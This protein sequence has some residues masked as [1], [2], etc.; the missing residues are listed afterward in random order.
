MAQNTIFPVLSWQNGD[1]ATKL[2]TDKNGVYLVNNADELRL[3]S[4][5][6]RK[7]T[8]FKGKKV[9][10]TADIDLGERPWYPIGGS[11]APFHGSF[12]GG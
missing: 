3:L 6:V 2:S 10:L 9:L 7:G 4:Y 5:L 8:T 11:G 1:A 12:D